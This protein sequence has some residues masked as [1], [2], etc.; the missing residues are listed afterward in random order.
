VVGRMDEKFM[1]GVKEGWK[2]C[3][4]VVGGSWSVMQCEL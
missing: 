4:F 2:L 3:A 1:L